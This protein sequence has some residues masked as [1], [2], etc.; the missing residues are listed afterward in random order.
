MRIVY[1]RADSSVSTS[2]GGQI[3]VAAGTHWDADDTLVL[4]HPELFSEDPKVGLSTSQ[5]ASAGGSRVI[6][7]PDVE[8]MTA[9]PG[10]RRMRPGPRERAR[11]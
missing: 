10:E 9:A 6:I 4:E 1:A 7:G 3:W 5:E 2:W 11:A 8:Q